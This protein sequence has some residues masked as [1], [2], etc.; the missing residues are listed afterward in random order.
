[1]TAPHHTRVAIIGAGFAGLGVA[2]RLR[3]LEITDFVVFERSS[4]V[5][6]TWRDNT[7]PGAGCDVP[8]QLYSYS[9]AR[10]PHWTHSFSTQPQIQRYVQDVVDR[11]GVRESIVFD[12]EVTGA[13]WNDDA[14]RWEIETTDG[15]Y[16]ADIMV[17]A[18]GP[19]SAPNRP[20]I[21]GIDTFRGPIFHSARWDHDVELAGKRVAVV[22]TGASA[23]QIVPSIAGAVARLD[24]YQRSAP[25]VLPRMGRK[26]SRLERLYYRRVPG[27]QR[28]ARSGVYWLRETF[29]FWQS[30]YPPLADFFAAGARVKMWWVIRDRELRRKLTP[31]YRLGCKRMLISNVYYPALTRDNVEVVTDGIAEIREQSIV[32]D[33]GTDREVDAIV[34]A[35]GFRIAD[36]PTYELITG[37]DGRT[38]AE[39]FGAGG[40]NVYKGTTIANFPNMFLMIGPNSALSYTSAIFTI[41]AQINYII[42]AI[43]T[44]DGTGL[45]T[46]E[47]RADAQAAYNRD[48]QTKFDG[49]VWNAGDCTSWFVDENGHNATLWPDFSFRFRRLLQTFDVE[50]YATTRSE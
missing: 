27:A 7:Y 5:G 50:A 29:V 6:G 43:T 36:S 46:V 9:F 37:R 10:N 39:V 17:S 35:T 26:Y 22:G 42:D 11:H 2:I 33:D 16:T 3:Q 14:A 31:S 49:T 23:I 8:S 13:R 45:R 34:L 25:W 18:A 41:E 40:M 15:A 47:V 24:L 19:L 44:M 28:L 38:L 1:M 4:E 32:A 21:K 48:L 30:K 20:D 12:C